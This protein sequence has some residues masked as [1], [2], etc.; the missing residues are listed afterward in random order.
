MKLW[1]KIE[2]LS[3]PS[4]EE[5]EADQNERK[6]QRTRNKKEWQIYSAKYKGLYAERQSRLKQAYKEAW[7]RLQSLGHEKVNWKENPAY[8]SG[9]SDYDDP[10]KYI[11]KH[12]VQS[13]TGEFTDGG[14]YWGDA[15]LPALKKE[16]IQKNRDRCVGSIF[17]SLHPGEFIELAEGV[18]LLDEDLD[19]KE[20]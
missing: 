9:H 17:E 19:L 3:S 5:E 8:A 10:D 2:V 1:Q 13:P 4:I 20:N 6:A 11:S 7:E 16:D 12:G 14:A 18:F 15:I